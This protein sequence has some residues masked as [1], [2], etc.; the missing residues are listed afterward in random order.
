[1]AKLVPVQDLQ[2]AFNNAIAYLNREMRQN[3]IVSMGQLANRF[4]EEFDCYAMWDQAWNWDVVG[5]KND[6][7]HM[8]FVLKWS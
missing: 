8:M 7:Q 5:F 2:P 4:K 6:E 3:E 1:M